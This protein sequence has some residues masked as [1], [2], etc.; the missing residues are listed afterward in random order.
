MATKAKKAKANKVHTIGTGVLSWDR[1]E[2]VSGRYGAVYLM[3]PGVNSESRS[4]TY[5]PLDIPDGRGTLVAIVLEAQQSTHIGDFFRGFFPTT[6]EVGEEI[7]L[8][9]GVIVEEVNAEGQPQIAVEPTD[10]RASD[11][12]KPE[13]LYRAHEQ[14]VRLEVRR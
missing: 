12:L 10:G 6:P 13:A 9:S 4:A 2:R 3:G 1:E 11:W 8:G 14:T 7:V 5:T